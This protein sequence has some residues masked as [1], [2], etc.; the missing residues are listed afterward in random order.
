MKKSESVFSRVHDKGAGLHDTISARRGPDAKFPLHG[1]AD[2]HTPAK[3]IQAMNAPDPPVF[4]AA[5]AAEACVFLLPRAGGA[6][7]FPQPPFPR[8]PV[9]FDAVR[10]KAISRQSVT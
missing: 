6:P 9:R 2:D 7:L 3:R 4:A 8:T 5:V 10:P 1:G